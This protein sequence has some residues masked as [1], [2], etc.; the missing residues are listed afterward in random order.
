LESIASGSRTIKSSC[1]FQ[2]K[3]TANNSNWPDARFEVARYRLGGDVALLGDGHIL[4][5]TFP[6]AAAPTVEAQVRRNCARPDAE[7]EI[8][9]NGETLLVLPVHEPLL[10]PEYR[11]LEFRSL[12]A[13]TREFTAGW[14]RILISVGA[15]GVLLAL[16]FTLLTAH[17]VSRPLRDLGRP[18]APRRK[19]R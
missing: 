3:T 13:A 16:L 5:S 10:G 6:A 11:L 7:C 14:S 2:I 19:G 18:V 15:G 8:D 4:R 1:L 17:F 12:D 9:R